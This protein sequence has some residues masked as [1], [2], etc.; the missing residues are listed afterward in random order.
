M[1]YFSGLFCVLCETLKQKQASRSNLKSPAAAPT[2]ACGGDS[3]GLSVAQACLE[4]CVSRFSA[5]TGIFSSHPSSHNIVR[6]TIKR[7]TESEYR[8]SLLPVSLSRTSISIISSQ[9]TNRRFLCAF[10]I[11]VRDLLVDACVHLSP[12]SIPSSIFSIINQQAQPGPS[13]TSRTPTLWPV[14]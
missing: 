10:P 14:C 3:A 11:R 7:M 8:S 2:M 9:L 5:E 1:Q 13:G 12:L 6:A 4:H